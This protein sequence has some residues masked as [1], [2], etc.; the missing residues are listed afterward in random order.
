VL[1]HHIQLRDGTCRFKTCERP[2]VACDLDHSQRHPDGRTCE[3]NMGPFCKRHHIFK[4]LL[5]GV[6]AHL[7]QADPGTFVWTM[8]TGH[9]YTTTPPAIGPPIKDERPIAPAVDRNEPPPF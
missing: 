8:P 3:R 5:D 2:A 7:K 6:L 4:H 1:R 9:V